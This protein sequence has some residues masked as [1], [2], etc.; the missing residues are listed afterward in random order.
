MKISELTEAELRT[1]LRRADL[2]LNIIP[3]VVRLRSDIPALARDIALMYGDFE[4]SETDAFADFHVEVSFERGL[5]RWIK[6]HARFFFDG[7]PSF[8]SLPVGQAF[9]M[10]EWGNQ[11]VRRGA[12]SPIPD[13][14]RSRSRK[15]W[16]GGDFARP[17]RFGKKHALR[18]VDQSRLAS[19]F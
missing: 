4:T 19:P 7:R 1:R 13:H 5:R 15:G 2:L 14:P 3:F 8:V 6:P 16:E 17:A 12:Q 11:L 18:G 10:L 9:A